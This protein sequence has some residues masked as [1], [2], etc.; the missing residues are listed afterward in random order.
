MLALRLLICLEFTFA[1]GQV[2]SNV[3][4]A[5][6]VFAYALVPSAAMLAIGNDERK[7]AKAMSDQ[8][9]SKADSLHPRM[10][11]RFT[12]KA[13]VLVIEIYTTQNMWRTCTCNDICASTSFLHLTLQEDAKSSS[14]Y[15]M[16]AA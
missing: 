13:L 14:T 1:S 10:S 9:S 3:L 2:C 5:W 4:E 12:I 7:A 11:I 16:R 15:L 6:M 8:T